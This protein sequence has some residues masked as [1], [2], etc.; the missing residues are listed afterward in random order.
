MACILKDV[1]IKVHEYIK[2][3]L[4]LRVEIIGGSHVLIKVLIKL[5]F[6]YM[7]CLLRNFPFHCTTVVRGSL[8]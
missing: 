3:E 4:L 7:V 2:S 8:K 6:D 1:I 5:G